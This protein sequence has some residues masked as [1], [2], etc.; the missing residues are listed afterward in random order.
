M[1]DL[2][3]KGMATLSS[4][5][6]WRTPWTTVGLPFMC[7]QSQL[8]LTHMERVMGQLQ[9]EQ[10]REAEALESDAEARALG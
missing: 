5:L 2:P 4:I 9:A 6:P 1:E 7:L 3:E 10:D 8:T